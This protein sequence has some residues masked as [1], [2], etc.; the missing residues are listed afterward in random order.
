MK[1]II[2]CVG[3]VVAYSAC[4]ASQNITFINKYDV[5]VTIKQKY[6]MQNN[7]NIYGDNIYKL[8]KDA[9]IELI[10]TKASDM[11]ILGQINDKN[12]LIISWASLPSGITDG[13]KTASLKVLIKELGDADLIQIGPDICLASGCYKPAIKKR[14]M[15]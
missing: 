8:E 13:A 9:S 15:N 11:N 10:V 3:V 2:F 7:P 5:P 1:L 4:N 12:P 14:L 6:R